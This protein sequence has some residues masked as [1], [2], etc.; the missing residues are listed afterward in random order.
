MG[1]QVRRESEAT[2]ESEELQVTLWRE[3]LD[4]LAILANLEPRGR[5]VSQVTILVTT[6]WK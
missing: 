2:A 1:G 5:M 4:P 6:V 3:L